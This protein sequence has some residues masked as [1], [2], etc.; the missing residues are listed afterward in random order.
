MPHDIIMPALGMAQD[1]G[2]L[3]AWHKSEGEAVTQGDALFEVETDK[4][5]MDVEAPADGYLVNVTAKDGDEVPVGKVI[6]QIS[7]S[8]EAPKPASDAATGPESTESAADAMP[9]GEPVIM[10][11]LGM[12]Q[13]SGVL[14]NWHKDLGDA[15]EQDD[16]LF[17]VE[18][19]KS[20][21]EV[22][23]GASGYVAARLAAA[24]DEV[25]TGET[26]AIIS[27]E[28]P[29]YTID[30]SYS[31]AA[32]DESS[33][34]KTEVAPEKPTAP[35]PSKAASQ[36]AA[37]ATRKTPARAPSGKVLAS[38]KLK[39][40]AHQAGLDLALLAASGQ[41]QP[42]LSRD[43]DALKQA[44]AASTSRAGAAM[45]A[46]VNR[47]SARV[48]AQALEDFIEWATSQLEG[49]SADCVIATFA[50]ASLASE[51]V[52][53]IDKPGASEAYA[54]TH[55]LSET[56]ATDAEPDLTVHDLRG[57]FI[58]QAELSADAGPVLAIL[59]QDEELTLTLM[60]TDG[61]M[62]AAD[63]ARLLNNFAGRVADP[64]RHLF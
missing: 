60:S 5:T 2:T 29:A 61:Q 13:D 6:A 34:R 52:V 49:V 42:F 50:G 58:S 36:P 17:D 3:I 10:P 63:A 47:L 7:E 51:A 37:P 64:V 26:I 38:P 56:M 33:N 18:T 15:V 28:A 53:R 46:P 41:P 35:T 4:T 8:A 20:V 22:Q 55:Q 48:P 39:R 44:N 25:P 30:R 57:T 24:G 32:T 21:V 11:V 43:F 40:L 12:S 45:A 27:A 19:D 54:T 16:I 9:E 62:P 23:A 1:T 59:G 14:V 31:E